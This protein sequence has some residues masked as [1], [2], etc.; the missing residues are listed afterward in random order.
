[1]RKIIKQAET[2]E[3]LAEFIKITREG[4][5][6]VVN[7]CYDEFKN[8]RKKKLLEILTDEQFGLC[9]YTG[10]PVDKRII[11]LQLPAEG[12]LLS[13]HIEHLKCQETC[14]AELADLG[15]I[16]G[17][18][19]CD[20]LSYFNMISAL[21][22]RGSADERFGAVFKD[23]NELAIWPTH[24]G[25]E[26]RF[27]FREVDGEVEGLDEEAVSSIGVLKLNHDTLVGWRKAAIDTFLDPAVVSTREDFEAVLDA[28][29]SPRNGR[30]P[31]FSFSIA[32]VAR[33][34]LQQ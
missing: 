29:D 10:A 23:N 33:Q 28:V 18:D 20:D 15:L 25:C 3:C 1:M 21:E 24:D 12:V 19:L 7:L 32:S 14:K 17:R 30:L 2:P 11:N 4:E 26:S 5:D 13:N 6:P 34:Y 9:G 16:H 8:P 27:R 31:E 22:I